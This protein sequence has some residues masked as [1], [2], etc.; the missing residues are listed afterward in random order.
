MAE[1][2]I[3]I[4]FTRDQALVLS[5]WLY[6]ATYQSDVLDDLLK[7]DRAVWSPIYTISGAL[8]ATLAEIFMPDYDERLKAARQRLLVEM[9][10]S[11]EEAGTGGTAF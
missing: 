11:D 6:Q 9:Y 2:P 1:E 4:K 10:G 5:D 7:T 3:T 8:E